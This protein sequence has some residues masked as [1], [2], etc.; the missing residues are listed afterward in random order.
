M[1]VNGD[2][3]VDEET[4]LGLARAQQDVDTSFES[5][6]PADEQQAVSS[7]FESVCPV[8]EFPEADFDPL[9]SAKTLDDEG[10]YLREN[11][12]HGEESGL[13]GTHLGL[14]I[15]VGDTDIDTSG[16][17]QGW[18]DTM[19]GE[20]ESNST[21]QKASGS[22]TQHAPSYAKGEQAQAHDESLGRKLELGMGAGETGNRVKGHNLPIL[23]RSNPQ[24]TPGV[25]Y[26]PPPR[27][28]GTGKKRGEYRK[29]P[30]RESYTS[31]HESLLKSR[32]SLTFLQGRTEPVKPLFVEREV[33]VSLDPDPLLNASPTSESNTAA[34]EQT[35]QQYK[36]EVSPQPV[37]D[38]NE[39]VS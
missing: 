24:S 14:P 1:N 39:K 36:L 33:R 19:A 8:D 35:F 28:K 20:Y 38:V 37:T 26:Q 10:R 34:E 6:C 30:Y 18:S 9:L 4:D 25:I 13:L 3:K 29:E 23:P 15:D 12:E 21:T 16:P 17:A 11:R 27:G 5:V 31:C 7:G 22:G 32:P 2:D